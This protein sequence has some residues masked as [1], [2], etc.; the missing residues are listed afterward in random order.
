MIERDANFY[1]LF[2]D[3]VLLE[4]RNF[5]AHEV[6][7]APK[8]AYIFHNVPALL[9]CNFCDMT[10]DEA[11]AII[12]SRAE[13]LGLTKWVD[14]CEQNVLERLASDNPNTTSPE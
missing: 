3:K 7:Y 6:Q 2:L 11:F 1:L 10:G 4:I 9:R 8:I 13:A 5:E 14:T 12:R